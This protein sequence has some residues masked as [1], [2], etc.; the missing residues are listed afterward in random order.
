MVWV[1][2]R[3]GIRAPI[4]VGI[5]V[6]VGV[7]IRV[8]SSPTKQF[9][10]RCARTARNSG[11]ELPVT[12]TVRGP[13]SA[14]ARPGPAPG[15]VRRMPS[16]GGKYHSARQ[17][18]GRAGWSRGHGPDVPPSAQRHPPGE[19]NPGRSGSAMAASPGVVQQLPADHPDR[20]EDGREQRGVAKCATEVACFVPEPEVP[21]YGRRVTF[22]CARVLPADVMIRSSRVTR[23][24]CAAKWG[25]ACSAP[26]SA[27]RA[28]PW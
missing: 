24:L 10:K 23:L 25:T 11:S 19:G 9:P 16:P 4:G 17:T 20:D 14:S 18:P 1:P 13:R 3:V 8:A 7:P 28:G 27:L 15:R 22:G 26:S 2:I 6:V 21:Q 12:V 5:R